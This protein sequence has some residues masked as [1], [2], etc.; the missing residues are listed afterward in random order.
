MNALQKVILEG[1][2]E[3]ITECNYFVKKY[4]N[5]KEE[6]S[7]YNGIVTKGRRLVIPL[8][9]RSDILN[10]LHYGHMGVEKCKRR[11]REVVFW[12]GIN[13]DIEKKVAEC[14]VCNK[15][16]RKQTKQPLKPHSVPL[17]PWQKLGLDLFE[18]NRK[19]FLTV[20]DYFSKFFEICE[21]QSTTSSSIIN[22][23]KPIFSRHGIPEELI[24]D[25]APNL[26]SD[27]FQRFAAEYGL[28]T[29]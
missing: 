5:F 1:W 10:Q 2:P 14:S 19:S 12:I 27:E 21:L 8:K 6:L 3:D 22:K 15:Y 9:L 13:S 11:A 4:W 28:L 18:L 29:E 7:L 16:K 23:L 25:N 20:V 24:S 26:V 17:R